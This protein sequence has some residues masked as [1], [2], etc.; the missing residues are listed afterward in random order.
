MAW[1]VWVNE[2]AGVVGK[3]EGGGGGGGGWLWW[4]LCV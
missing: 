2:S 3:M 1:G 4:W